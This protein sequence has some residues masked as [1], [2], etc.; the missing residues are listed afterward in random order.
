MG[1]L[2][3]SQW[4][5]IVKPF[6]AWTLIGVWVSC[7][8]QPS[9]SGS[10]GGAAF[11]STFLA[12]TLGARLF[13][14]EAEGT[15][16]AWLRSLP[17]SRAKLYGT[18]IALGIGALAA[19]FLIQAAAWYSPLGELI[20]SAREADYVFLEPYPLDA[21]GMFAL[22]VAIFAASAWFASAIHWLPSAREGGVVGWGSVMLL[23]A[24]LSETDSVLLGL[25]VVLTP[26]VALVAAARYSARREVA[27][28]TRYQRTLGPPAAGAQAL[29]TALGVF[30]QLVLIVVPLALLVSRWIEQL[31]GLE[32]RDLLTANLGLWLLFG[33]W[34]FGAT[35]VDVRGRGLRGVRAL[36][37]LL[38]GLSG[39]GLALWRVL[40]LPGAAAH[41]TL[42]GDRRQ[43]ALSACPTC[44]ETEITAPIPYRPRRPPTPKMCAFAAF[45][46]LIFG[47]LGFS[48]VHLGRSWEVRA[49]DSYGHFINGRAPIEVLIDGRTVGEGSAS[50]SVPFDVRVSM[51]GS[52]GGRS[53]LLDGTSEVSVDQILAKLDHHA[54]GENDSLSELLQLCL[55]GSRIEFRH[56]GAVLPMS[57]VDVGY[58]VGG[59]DRD[60]L[61]LTF[62]LDVSSQAGPGAALV[63]R[64]NRDG[65]SA[66]D[67]IGAASLDRATIQGL[68]A[69][70]PRYPLHLD[71]ERQIL[72]TALDE[73]EARERRDL[74]AALDEL[75][76]R[77]HD[78]PAASAADVAALWDALDERRTAAERVDL[79][80]D[81][82]PGHFEFR[83]DHWIVALRPELRAL[84]LAGSAG[85]ARLAA[86]LDSGGIE[87]SIVAAWTGDPRWFD[88]CAEA[89]RA[90]TD[91][92]S[93]A[94][95]LPQLSAERLVAG[96]A[97]LVL[98][99]RAGSEV[100]ADV[101]RS[102]PDPE[103]IELL[104]FAGDD[105]RDA[106]AAWLERDDRELA[107]ALRLHRVGEA[108][109]LR[110]RIE[111]AAP[112]RAPLEAAWDLNFNLV[113]TA[114]ARLESIANEALPPT[115]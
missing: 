111:A 18:K 41:C 61:K 7:W 80:L 59:G 99:P 110:F 108:R 52:S 100:L 43:V 65:P 25:L 19:H 68:V 82:G 72:V 79:T 89:F 56:G 103:A 12:A 88:A 104:P 1:V 66:V 105:A 64:I 115:D 17:I 6:I 97:M 107:R 62:D 69:S 2:I 106:A 9:F 49:R 46:L 22:C 113:T 20:A 16:G 109:T 57:R 95:W 5:L 13:A 92:R 29:D 10:T 55:G 4:R 94:D 73:V 96:W 36:P 90:G 78:L 114:G 31:A 86:E 53:I 38:L 76:V 91:R 30:L 51:R 101:L 67:T 54:F 44:G 83:T 60:H 21:L 28:T 15:Q 27:V 37:A 93:N 102:A 58:R 8:L 14:H 70:V 87:A 26:V 112:L 84:S 63:E 11:L 81:A 35:R 75:L 45:F 40:R 85:A 39:L 3:Q 74:L 50:G 33:L 24:S 77:R 71:D 98:D 48:A 32:G 23:L 42:C 34:R 47:G